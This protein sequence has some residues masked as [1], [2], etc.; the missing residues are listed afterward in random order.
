M[1]DDGNEF[2]LEAV[3]LAEALEGAVQPPLVEGNRDQGSDDD[4]RHERRAVP[5][6]DERHGDTLRNAPAFTFIVVMTLALMLPGISLGGRWALCAL[7]AMPIALA[8]IS[9]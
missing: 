1:R 8:R 4:E 6:N 5:E 2:V 3:E 9:A 7:G